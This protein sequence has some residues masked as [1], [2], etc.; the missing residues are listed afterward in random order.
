MRPIPWLTELQRSLL[1]YLAIRVVVDQTGCDEQTA[2][3]VL[4]E[5]AGRG[6]VVLRGDDRNVWLIACGNPLV[7]STH[8]W[9]AAHSG[10]PSAN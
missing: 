1:C 7:H 4:D 8:G 6:D 9:L 10:D 3:D 5:L 2:A